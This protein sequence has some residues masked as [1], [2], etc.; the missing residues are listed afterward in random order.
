MK[1]LTWYPISSFCKKVNSLASNSLNVAK[2]AQ[3]PKRTF[4]L[5]FGV[6]IP[7]KIIYS[8]Q[9]HTKKR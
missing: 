2:E 8:M 3:S 7:C 5:Y 6:T 1:F 4:C 9:N